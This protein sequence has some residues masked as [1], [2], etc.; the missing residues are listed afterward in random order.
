[1][2]YRL[3]LSARPPVFLVRRRFARPLGFGN[4][5][6]PRVGLIDDG[7]DSKNASAE[8]YVLEKKWLAPIDTEGDHKSYPISGDDYIDYYPRR[9][10]K[11]GSRQNLVNPPLQVTEQTLRYITMKGEECAAITGE[12]KLG[13]FKMY[14]VTW[15]A[16][17][18]ADS[19]EKDMINF[20]QSLRL[21]D[22]P[23]SAPP[24]RSVCKFAS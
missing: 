7:C 4:P 20:L 21:E 5:A 22:V 1:V 3:E 2:F 23:I 19:A 18:K 11:I 24:D 12:S 16:S 17:G 8:A 13:C 10:T 9:F 6:V 14:F 15:V